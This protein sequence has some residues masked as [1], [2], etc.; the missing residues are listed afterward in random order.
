MWENYRKTGCQIRCTDNLL[1]QVGLAVRRHV[2]LEVRKE[3]FVEEV[4]F[5]QGMNGYNVMCGCDLG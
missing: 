2:T 3:G 1:I 4:A 5:D